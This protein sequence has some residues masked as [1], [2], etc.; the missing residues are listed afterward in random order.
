[1]NWTAKLMSVAAVTFLFS[2]L[3]ASGQTGQQG[4]TA[5]R[6]ECLL[7]ARADCPNHV[8]SINNR[9][10]RLNTEI[11]KGTRAYTPQELSYLKKELGQYQAMHDYIDRNAP[12]GGY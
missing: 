4:S 2:A 3:P 10:A 9:I 1:M 5:L 12:Q 7:V 8:D 6:D 11:A